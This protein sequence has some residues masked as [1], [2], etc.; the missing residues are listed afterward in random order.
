[1]ADTEIAALGRLGQGGR[2]VED[3]VSFSLAHRIRIE[4]RAALHE[5]PATS[6]QLA[7]IVGQ[8]RD[9]LN[10]HLKEMLNDGSIGIDRTEKVGNMDRHYYCAVE[11]PRFSD[12]QME[13]FSWEERQTICAI[14]VQAASTEA[15]ASLWAG[16]MADDPRVFL[17]WNRI[18]LDRQ[19]RD[20]LADEEAQTWTRRYG[21]AAEAASRLADSGE[22][23]VTYIITSFAYERSRTSAPKPLSVSDPLE[24]ASFRERLTALR[25]WRRTGQQAESLENAVSYS[26]GHRVRIEIRAALHEGPATASRLADILQEPINIIDYHLKEMLEDGSIDIAKTE[27]VGNLD[28]HYYSVINLPFFSDKEYAVMSRVDRQTLCGI[29]VQAAIAEAMASLWAGKMAAEPRTFLGWDRIVLDKQARE[30]LA[31]DEAASWQRK[32]E[33][34]VRSANRRAN[35]GEPG[36]TYII[37]SFSY[38]RSRNSAPDPLNEN[39]LTTKEV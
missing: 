2:G 30:D 35:S 14:A 28:Q 17:G 16:K 3:S 5:G 22:P 12:E 1:M 9:S 39:H 38:E 37:T 29:A 11:L 4:I 18:Q 25:K 36:T 23:G 32:Q 20:E 13:A 19:G 10:F 21:I 7:E 8:P 15:L 33:I 24:K 31:D 26:L 27:K 6:A 34:E